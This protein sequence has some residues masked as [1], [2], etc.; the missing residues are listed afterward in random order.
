MAPIRAVVKLV[1]MTRSRAAVKAVILFKWPEVEQWSKWSQDRSR[2]VV[3]AA[4]AVK[5]VKQC[6]ARV[7]LWPA[8]RG[9]PGVASRARLGPFAPDLR[10]FRARALTVS[11]PRFDRFGPAL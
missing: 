3:K 4:K 10:P 5:A 2:A 9:G 1:E 8:A 11:G 6:V 7:L